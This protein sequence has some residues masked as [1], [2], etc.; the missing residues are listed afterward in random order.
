MKLMLV[1]G[2]TDF[3]LNDLYRPQEGRT[4]RMI[5]GLM[6]YCKF[7]EEQVAKFRDQ[8]MQVD[9]C[10]EERDQISD[11]NDRVCERVSNCRREISLGPITDGGG[12][13]LYADSVRY[14]SPR[15]ISSGSRPRRSEEGERADSC[16]AQ[17]RNGRPLFSAKR[18]EHPAA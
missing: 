17:I 16:A 10:R 9:N 14:I 6:N 5:S 1:V 12:A 2:I 18:H 7:R 4:R 3:T 15:C 11:N 8:I 13:V